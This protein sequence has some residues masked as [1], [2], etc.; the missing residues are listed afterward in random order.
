MNNNYIIKEKL[1]LFLFLLYDIKLKN[2]DDKNE[3]YLTESINEVMKDFNSSNSLKT[4]FKERGEELHK[5]ANN[6]SIKI[7]INKKENQLSKKSKNILCFNQTFIIKPNVFY[8]CDNEL[9]LFNDVICLK[10]F[11]FI[12]EIFIEGF[13][14]KNK[15]N[16]NNKFILA[17]NFKEKNKKNNKK[18]IKRKL[19]MDN[20]LLKLKNLKIPEKIIL[21]KNKL[22]SSRMIN[23]VNEK[24]NIELPYINNINVIKKE[25]KR[26]QSQK[27]PLLYKKNYFKIF[28]LNQ[29]IKKEK[30]NQSKENYDYTGIFKLYNFL[31]NQNLV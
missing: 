18:Q 25:I 31:R 27:T 5:G 6:L 24:K 7:P 11:Q 29:N 12:K 15:Q 13:K 3:S 22:N 28:S 16:E 26:N 17:S 8:L 2:N 30:N 10:M 14:Y 23:N 20:L 9:M 4:Y 21:N 19:S 1:K